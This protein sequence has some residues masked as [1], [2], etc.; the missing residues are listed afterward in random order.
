MGTKQQSGLTNWYIDFFINYY[1]IF[2]VVF[3]AEGVFMKLYLDDLRPI[4]DGWTTA[5]TASEA[6][7][8]LATCR[9]VEI[10]FDHDLGESDPDL[11][12]WVSLADLRGGIRDLTEQHLQM[13]DCGTG[14]LVARWI[15]IAT[16][17]LYLPRLRWSI[18]SAN[19]VG[20]ENIIAAMTRVEQMWA[21]RDI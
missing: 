4:P 10:S 3:S 20:R 8:L 7:H 18:H 19:P 5:R 2:L 1:K 13:E 16:R 17:D 21:E 6:I 14:H 15:E 9:V 11:W 12:S